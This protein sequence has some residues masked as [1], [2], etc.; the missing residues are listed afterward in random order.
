M[1][2]RFAGIIKFHKAAAMYRY[3]RNSAIATLFQDFKYRGYKN[4]A[5]YLGALATTALD[6]RLFFSDI[7]I[8]IPVPIHWSKKLQRG[9]NQTVAI[10]HGISQQT[11]IPIKTQLIAQR[12]HKTQ[13]RKNANERRK[14]LHGVFKCKADYDLNH[15]HIAIVDDV[16]TTGA[17]LAEAATTVLQHYPK[18]KISIFALATTYN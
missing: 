8:I 17:T 9:Y 1:E 18:A 10:C 2:Q 16:C 4:L 7:D 3:T 6:V 13:T 15:L 14:N 12:P 5:K 11:G